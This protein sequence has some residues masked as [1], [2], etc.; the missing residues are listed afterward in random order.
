MDA[1]LDVGEILQGTTSTLSS[2]AGPAAIYVVVL[3]AV[4]SAVDL[5]GTSANII[6]TVAS[7]AGGFL[8]LRAMLV[9]EGLLDPGASNRFGAYFGLSL[10]SGLGILLGLVVLVI[11]GVV[12]IV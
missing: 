4:G 9:A 6:S 2:N 11:P 12:L 10:L 7:V 8:L 5:S 3:G 1:K